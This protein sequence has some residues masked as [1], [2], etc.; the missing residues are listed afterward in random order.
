M[1]YR[2]N[3]R[4]HT[5]LLSDC[6]DEY[7]PAYV[8]EERVSREGTDMS[9]YR[10]L[11]G[12]AAYFRE[13]AANFWNWMISKSFWGNLEKATMA[14]RGLMLAFMYATD[15]SKDDEILFGSICQ[16]FETR[17]DYYSSKASD[18]ERTA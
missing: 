5:I 7:S 8:K 9:D 18:I 13:E 6:A 10:E 15:I 2:I 4:H 11:F 17:L 16:E 12:T 14:L 1:A 3:R